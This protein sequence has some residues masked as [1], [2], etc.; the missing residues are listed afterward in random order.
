[1]SEAARFLDAWFAVRQLIQAANF[2]RFHK[3]GLSA[4][5]FMTLNLLPEHKAGMSIGELARRMNLKPATVAKTMDSLEI[6]GLVLR[7][8]DEADRRVVMVRLTRE[9]AKLQNSAAGQLRDQMV[10]IF[11][12]V[13]PRQRSELIVGLESLVRAGHSLGL[14]PGTIRD[15]ERSAAPV[16]RNSRRSPRL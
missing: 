2:N 12:A 5:Q 11:R 4:T 13:P 3:A 9:G 8:R 15:D 7:A 14:S 6:R 16:K 10:E 1:M